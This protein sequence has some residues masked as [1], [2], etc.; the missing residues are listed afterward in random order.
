MV[1]K[2]TIVLGELPVIEDL[3]GSARFPA[4]VQWLPVLIEP[5]PSEVAE[6]RARHGRILVAPGRLSQVM[7]VVEELVLEMEDAAQMLP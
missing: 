4:I 1:T 6:A 5:S 2:P 3:Q 7:A